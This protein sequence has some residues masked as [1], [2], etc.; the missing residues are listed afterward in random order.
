MVYSQL[1]K[2]AVVELENSKETAIQTKN[3]IALPNQK[4]DG[5]NGNIKGGL[6]RSIGSVLRKYTGSRKQEE[7]TDEAN[8]LSKPYFRETRVEYKSASSKDL[9]S[10]LDWGEGDRKLGL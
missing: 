4:L 1:R 3:E 9:P 8:L 5:A 2:K 7:T 6:R 10:C